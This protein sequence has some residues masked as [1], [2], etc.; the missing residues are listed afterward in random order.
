MAENNEIKMIEEGFLSAK[1]NFD[2]RREAIS[3]EK[4]TF[5]DG[6]KTLYQNWK[7]QAMNACIPVTDKLNANYISIID[8]AEKLSK[9]MESIL[10]IYKNTDNNIANT[11]QLGN[12]TQG[13]K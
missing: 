8:N 1:N 13:E 4:N 2:E 7:G 5:D 10:E 11:Y 3:T 6:K 9:D 12:S